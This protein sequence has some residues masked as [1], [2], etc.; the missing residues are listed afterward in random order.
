M[1]LGTRIKR[2][3]LGTLTALALATV[4]MIATAQ[5]AQAA[6]PAAALTICVPGSVTGNWH[7]INANTNAMTRVNVSLTCNGGASY[8]VQAWGKCHPTD[9]FWGTQTAT[10]QGGGWI[11]AVYNFGFKTSSVWLRTYVYSGV[12]YLRVYVYNDFTPSDGRTDYVTDEWM[13]R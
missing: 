12:T 6:K 11:R 10:N 2:Y 1:Q 5:P 9:C 3:A 4:G 7:N 13:L 8:P